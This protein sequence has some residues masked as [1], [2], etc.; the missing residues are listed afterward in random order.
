MLWQEIQNILDT[1]CWKWCH[2][3]NSPITICKY[4]QYK[5]ININL[6]D[7]LSLGHNATLPHQLYHLTKK[8]VLVE[9]ESVFIT[10]QDY[11]KILAFHYLSP[12]SS[13][14]EFFPL[15]CWE[16]KSHTHCFMELAMSKSHMSSIGYSQVKTGVSRWFP[17]SNFPVLWASQ[18]WCW[19][20]STQLPV[21]VMAGFI[22]P[23]SS[24]GLWYF[25]ALPS[26]FLLVQLELLFHLLCQPW[27]YL[28]W[29]WK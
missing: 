12:F 20:P 5:Y 10:A 27:S 9:Q 14:C 21:F 28:V 19:V 23:L 11:R 25:Q 17:H 18:T 3:T 2:H 22:F 7:W 6:L 4:I 24:W 8:K 29:M 15:L 16:C 26:S 1:K 13:C